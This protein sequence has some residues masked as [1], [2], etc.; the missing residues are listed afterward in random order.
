MRPGALRR[1]GL[2]AD[3]LTSRYPELGLRQGPRVR[4]QGSRRRSGRV[5][6][7]GLLGPGRY[8]AHAHPARAR[9]SHRAA[10]R[11]GGPQRRA[12]PGLRRRGGPAQAV[13]HGNRIGRRRLASRRRPCGPCRR[14]SWPRSAG[15]S[16]RRRAGEGRWSTRSSASTGRRTV[17][18]FSSSS[19]SPTA[20]GPT[21]AGSS[22]VP[23]SPRIRA[24]PTS[25]SGGRTARRV[26]PSSTRSSPS[27]PSTSGRRCSLASTRPGLRC[28]PF[29]SSS[30]T[31]R[32][33]PT[34]TSATW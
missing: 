19:S 6:R 5:R 13:A 16:R 28:S 10:W 27:E 24:S 7:H 17:A 22:D 32:W 20:T 18:T 34:G 4:R 3:A 8:G 26:S 14:T 2:D 25:W 33:R 23:T 29:R 21:S 30:T 1:A 31:R 11:H 9:L 15:T 12:G